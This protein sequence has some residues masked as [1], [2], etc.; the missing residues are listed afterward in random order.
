MC[1]ICVGGGLTGHRQGMRGSPL[2]FVLFFVLVLPVVVVVAVI[3]VDI[4]VLI[5]IV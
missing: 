4:I 1:G 5:V 2:V 3:V